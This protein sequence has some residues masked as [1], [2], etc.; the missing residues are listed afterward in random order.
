MINSTYN[1]NTDEQ[2]DVDTLTLTED[3]CHLV[4]WNDEVNTFEWVI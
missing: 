3:P 4:V 2:A 1:T